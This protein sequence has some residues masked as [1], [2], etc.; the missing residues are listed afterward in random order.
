LK[1]KRRIS[2]ESIKRAIDDCQST[3]LPTPPS[4]IRGGKRKHVSD[5]EEEDEEDQ[6]EDQRDSSR[7]GKYYTRKL[8]PRST[9]GC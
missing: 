4:S 9:P 7:E 2:P 1:L 8:N 6:G 5:D 3:V